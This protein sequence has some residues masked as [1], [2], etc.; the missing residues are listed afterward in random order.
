MNVISAAC[1]CNINGSI[2]TFC[3]SKLECICKDNI[4][5]KKCTN[6]K[7]GYTEFPNCTK[8]KRNPKPNTLNTNQ[9][10]SFNSNNE[11]NNQ[12]NIEP[13]NKHNNE[14]NN[15]PNIK[16]NIKPNNQ[17]NIKPNIKPNNKPDE[18]KSSNHTII[19]TS[20][21]IDAINT[22]IFVTTG[23]GSSGDLSSSELIN[24]NGECTAS[25]PDYPV[26]LH[27]ATGVFV[28]GTIIIC[29]G[30]PPFSNKCY[31]LK[32]GNGNFELVY[33]MEEYRYYAESVA[34][35]GKMLV[36]GGYNGKNTIGTGEYI[37]PQISNNTAPGPNIQLPEP[38]YHHAIV[39]INETTTYLI[40]GYTTTYSKKTYFYN[41]VSKE[42]ASGPELKTGRAYHTAGVIID[43][44]T[45]AQHIAVVGGWGLDSVELLF[46]ED[47]SWSEGKL[48]AVSSEIA[49]KFCDFLIN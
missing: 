31:Q 8:I 6:C 42:W 49:N 43:H 15:K 4:S 45:F 12:P 29:G 13:N 16:P 36:L 20:S 30:Y 7:S 39:N 41:H 28:D 2:S 32:N 14:P 21:T 22:K 9:Y 1:D 33:R 5:G 40:G 44:E 27:A 25:L 18:I 48:T 46:H 38:V 23:Y 37:I 24:I 47:N 26:K 34:V 3:D 19:T 17:P 10:N 35:Q 11:P